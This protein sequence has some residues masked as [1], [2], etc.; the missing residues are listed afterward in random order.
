M[1]KRQALNKKTC[2]V[3]WDSESLKWKKIALTEA[4]IME[5][6]MRCHIK[7]IRQK[8][9]CQF[10]WLSILKILTP[11]KIESKNKLFSLGNRGVSANI[12]YKENVLMVAKIAEGKLL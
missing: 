10:R 5:T 1:A 12:L 2:H 11:L 8:K 9:T 6:R 7:I 4:S 3:R